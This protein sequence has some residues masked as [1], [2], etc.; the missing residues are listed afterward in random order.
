M[1]IS[2]GNVAILLLARALSHRKEM[3]V[4]AALG[5]NRLRLAGQILV[6]TSVLS[7]MGA[8]LGLV[9]SLSVIEL[10]KKLSL[11][12]VYRVEYRFQEMSLDVRAFLFVFI[13][14]GV[15]ALLAGILPAWS[16]SKTDAGSELNDSGNRTG[17]AGP[18][19]Q[20]EQSILVIGQVALACVLLISTGL[21]TRSFQAAQ[22]LPLSFDPGHVL[23][24]ELWLKAKKYS[25]DDDQRPDQGQKQAFW[26]A[27]LEKARQPPGV[28]A[29]AF[30]DFPP[31]LLWRYRLGCADLFSRC[32][33][34]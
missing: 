34:S 18:G 33:T 14:T 6:E 3:S 12:S 30:N 20:R 5:A 31:F 32:W 10:I 25:P 4:R 7:L 13:V 27:V 11:G 22:N 17:T 26:A 16:L 1:L 21:L 9:V 19:R 15:V 8:L 23:T 24:A 29:A 28:Q 2:C